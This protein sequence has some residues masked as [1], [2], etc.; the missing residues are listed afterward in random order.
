MSLVV[1][2]HPRFIDHDTGAWHPERPSRLDAVIRGI[3]QADIS[4]A[5]VK[6]EPRLA[7]TAEVEAVHHA[8]LLPSL[9]DV[10]AT[11]GGQL[12]PDTVVSPDSAEAALYAAGAGPTAIAAL[13]AG[14]AE[15]AFCAVR[16]PGHHATPDRAM[17]FCLLNNVAVAAAALAGRGE[18]V[19]IVDFDAHHGNGTQDIF[20]GDDRVFYV[21]LHEHPLFPGTGRADEVGTGAGEGYTL[22]V[23]LPSG[24][25]GDVWGRAL[26]ELVLP[27]L[28]RFEPTWLLLSAGFDG[29]RAD[30][31]TG[32]ALSAGDYARFVS[33]LLRLAPAGQRLVFLE[34]GYDLDALR[35]STAATLAA[36]LDQPAVTE[37]ASNGGPGHD[38]V[39]RILLWRNEAGLH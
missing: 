34:G 17:G 3:D 23:P 1:V 37:A 16:P 20:F 27:A 15:A 31:L 38:V 28:E 7:T 2:T 12:D 36:L 24:S 8:D 13:D 14:Q 11:G 29:H 22:N 10:A 26:Y 18:R 30:P 21:S 33:M 39:E 5:V 6:V 25:T 9:I 32:L 35:D 4:E 19:A